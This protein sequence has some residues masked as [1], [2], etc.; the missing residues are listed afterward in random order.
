[1]SEYQIETWSQRLKLAGVALVIWAGIVL[2]TLLVIIFCL[3]IKIVQERNTKIETL[4]HL[5]ERHDHQRFSSL[6]K[7][8]LQFTRWHS[9]D[10]GAWVSVYHLDKPSQQKLMNG[11][12]PTSERQHV[13]C[14]KTT[15]ETS[16]KGSHLKLHYVVPK[17]DFKAHKEYKNHNSFLLYGSNQ[18]LKNIEHICDQGQFKVLQGTDTLLGRGF[19][20]HY[21]AV[22]AEQ[23]YLFSVYQLN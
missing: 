16:W 11:D 22:D 10:H 3:Y 7:P 4:S 18:F 23:K 12:Y 13:E 14:I 2:L 20:H 21:W 17:T 9:A 6:K 1:M 8:I 19:R 5:S 15:I